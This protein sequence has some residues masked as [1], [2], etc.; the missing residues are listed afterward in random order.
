MVHLFTHVTESKGIFSSY[1]R[2]YLRRYLQGTCYSILGSF[3]L[4]S[5]VVLKHVKTKYERLIESYERSKVFKCFVS[6]IIK[7]N[8]W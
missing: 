1:L 5:G 7:W 2:R 8:I 4:L 3:I 6:L